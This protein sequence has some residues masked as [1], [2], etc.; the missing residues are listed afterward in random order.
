MSSQTPTP[1]ASTLPVDPPLDSI[2]PICSYTLPAGH[3]KRTCPECGNL[4]TAIVI[5]HLS[6]PITWS[7]LSIRFCSPMLG[8]VP[9]AAL[10]GSSRIL[11]SALL[12]V[13]ALSV[14][15]N[16]SI[17]FILTLDRP[18]AEAVHARDPAERQR[19]ERRGNVGKVILGF[20]TMAICLLL[21]STIV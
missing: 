3:S 7:S 17:Q 19:L 6:H 14:M 16:T 2:C 1:T 13:T 18:V 10:A 4:V 5:E 11:S 20:G 15:I 21:L 12:I 8:L 9:A